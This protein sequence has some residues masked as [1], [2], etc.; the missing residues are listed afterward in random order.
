MVL[1]LDYSSLQ[2]AIKETQKLET[3]LDQYCDELS[4]KV[5]SKL[6]DVKGGMSSALN[7]ADYYINQKISQLRTKAEHATTLASRQNTLFDTAKRVD[8]DVKHMIEANQEQFFEKYPDLRPSDTKTKIYEFFVNLKDVPILGDIIRGLE[9]VV[10]ARKELMRNIR[11][12]WECGGGEA[13]VMNCVDILIVVGAAVLAVIAVIGSSGF[14]A[15]VA[16]VAAVI[17][18]VNAATNI[19][20]SVQAIMADRNGD[21]AMAKIYADRSS[22]AS[23]LRE[24][25]FHDRTLNRFSNTAAFAVE[26]TEAVTGIIMT[27][28]SIGKTIGKAVSG[29]A[30]NNGISF[31]F[32]E[33][34]RDSNGKLVTK[35]T[36]KSFWRGTKA[37]ILNE[38]LTASTAKGLRTTLFNNIK[39][40]FKNNFGYQLKLLKMAIRDPKGWAQKKEIGDLGFLKNISEKVRLNIALF[41]KADI[42]IKIKTYTSSLK[43][44]LTYFNAV[45]E[46][47]NK[48]DGRGVVNH[49]LEEFLPDK[50][51]D[52]D[53]IKLLNQ[54]G[55]TKTIFA[56]D[57]YEDFRY[58]TGIGKKDGLIQ[59]ID[60]YRESVRFEIPEIP[61]VTIQKPFLQYA[62]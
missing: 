35:I 31:A 62:A 13:L 38:K 59:K 18:I 42:T 57:K 43:T 36:L 15:V 22:L 29:F 47:L 2:N 8:G 27:V 32:K 55:V 51:F 60:K 45:I 37:M 30:K 14:L 46:G 41:K 20:T 44:G 11:Y 7:S 1:S 6:Y 58:Y 53:F 33:L 16:A 48:E 5:Q 61:V 26:I 19:V 50:F 52:S 40:S 54:I 9:I 17:A 39:A 34:T 10:D 4:K 21:P 49:S 3:E 28:A 12:W 23:V 56:D 24:E 25:N